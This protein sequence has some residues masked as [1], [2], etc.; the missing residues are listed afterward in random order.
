MKPFTDQV[1]T[2]KAAR[3][4]ATVALYGEFGPPILTTARSF[5]D[6]GIEAVVLAIGSTKP[7]LWSNAVRSAALMTLGD[8]GTPAGISALNNFI[9]QTNAQ[10]LLAFWDP[11][12]L[13]LAANQD[14][15]PP[16]C[17]LL[18]SSKDALGAVQSK[19]D[20]LQV[21][22]RCGFSVLPTWELS[23]VDDVCRIDHAAYPVCLRPSAPQGVTPTFKVEVLQSPSELKAFLAGRTWGPEPILVQPFLPHPSVVIHGVRSES[24]ELLALEGFIAPMKFEGISL[25]LRPFRM[26]ERIAEC[27]RNFVNE[28]GITGPFHFDLLYCAE[29][30]DFYYLEIN[31]R[32]GGTTDKVFRLGFDE[33]LLTLAAYGFEVPVRPYRAPKGRSVVNRKAVLKHMLCVAQG[34]LSPLDYPIAG[35][36]RHL[37]LSLRCLLWDK[38]SIA[39]VRDLRGTWLFFRGGPRSTAS[40]RRS[41]HQW[42][43]RILRHS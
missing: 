29:T 38:D 27:C 17:K 11:Q 34:R 7:S 16:G 22:Q 4:I 2:P 26:D 43:M 33:P 25:E 10:A 9:Q 5:R 18:M 24:G 36:F 1:K 37:L 42:M 14:S 28:V 21:A 13:W 8:V 40:S 15:L 20:Q 12:M 6:A 31:A 23:Q 32:L 3:K 30:G 39:S 19:D 35:G 41:A